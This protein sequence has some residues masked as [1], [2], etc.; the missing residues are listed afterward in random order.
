M[1]V[2]HIARIIV[3]AL[4]VV[5]SLIVVGLS[6]HLISLTEEYYAFYFVF[7][8]LGIATAV[9]TIFT[10]PVMLVVDVVRRGAFTSMII[11]ELVWLSVLWVF[12]VATAAEAVSAGNISFPSGCVYEKYATV[13]G[14]CREIQAVEAFS[15]L[16]FFVLLGYTI[17]LLVFTCIAASRGNSLWLKSVKDST[18]LAPSPTAPPPPQPMG[19]YQGTPAG[20]YQVP[21]QQPQYTGVSGQHQYTGS[22]AS[23]HPQQP[24]HPQTS[25]V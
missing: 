20:Q 19:H 15:F 3:L 12:W 9:L 22:P 7:C 17:V 16:A 14:A 2:F 5:F 11:V 6:G 13:N 21:V 8:A 18:F 24:Y 1:G 23:S 10:V 4:L 25:A